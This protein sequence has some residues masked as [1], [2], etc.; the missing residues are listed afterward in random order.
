ML[1]AVEGLHLCFGGTYC[2]SLHNRQIENAR[3]HDLLRPFCKV[4]KLQVDTKLWDLSLALS[5]NDNRLSLEILPQLHKILQ[6]DG[7]RFQDVFDGF[8]AAQ[9][10]AGQHIVK[11]RH[12]PILY[13]D[14]KASE[15]EEDA[16]ESD[17]E[18]DEKSEN[19]KGEVELG[20]EDEREEAKEGSSNMKTKSDIDP[21]TNNDPGSSTEVDSDSDFDSKSKS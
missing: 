17:G 18:E 8:I 21:G 10:N 16:D 2:W 9:W 11:H 1:S 15:G 14:S 4:E 5:L 3:W 6:L 20:V 13:P 19:N 7:V 12:V